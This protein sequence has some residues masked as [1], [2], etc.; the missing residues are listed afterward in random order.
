MK[1]FGF[2]CG[3]VAASPPLAAVDFAPSSLAG[4]SAVVVIS[5]GSGGLP[6]IGGYRILFGPPNSTYTINPLSSSVTASN[7]TYA[8]T[9]TADSAGRITL[10]TANGG[11][12]TT[13][14]LTFISSSTASFAISN[15]SGTQT[16]TL[17]LEDAMEPARACLINMSVRAQVM[18]GSQV[19]PGLVVDSACRVLIRV[20]G[21]ALAEFGI[22]GALP[23]PRLTLLIGD[24]SVVTND[25]WASTISNYDAVRAA[26]EKS[27]A[28]PFR[29]GSRDAAVVAD[30]AAGSYTCVV[31][32][33]PGTSGEVL[34][35][36][37]RV[38]ESR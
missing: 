35:E 26:A 15:P 27:G 31:T 23:N 32:G 8:Y 2:I 34:L 6:P 38:P 11:P 5:T 36:V 1:F 22:A 4:K 19:I 30:L 14:S 12:T 17:V 29:F 20:A 24:R 16:G 28:F 10:V 18:S 9:K 25:D 7:G 37:Y 21:P 13:Q 33:D 3:L